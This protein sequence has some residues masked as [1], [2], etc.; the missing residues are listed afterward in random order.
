[1]Y[2]KPRSDQ[3][4][5]GSMP[6][7][8]S[9]TGKM[10]AWGIVGVAVVLLIASSLHLQLGLPTLIDSALVATTVFLVKKQSPWSTLG[11]VS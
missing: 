4:G 1:M 7:P 3:V 11:Q 10:A 9:P 8:M 5:I 2:W 6:A